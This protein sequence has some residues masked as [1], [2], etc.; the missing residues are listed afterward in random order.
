MKS[1][2]AANLS[3]GTMT[4]D[5][6]SFSSEDQLFDA[7]TESAFEFIHKAIAEFEQS[8]K[9]STVNFAIAIELILKAKLLREHWSLLLEKPD[10]ADKDSFRKG[11]SHTISP[12]KTIE[13]LRRVASVDV[14][15]KFREIFKTI[16]THRNKMVHF[17]HAGV[18]ATADQTA[19][20]QIAEEQCAGWYALRFLLRQWPEFRKFDDEI[21]RIGRGMERHRAYLQHAFDAKAEDLNKHRKAGLPIRKCPV[22]S[23]DSVMVEESDGTIADTSCVVCWYGGSEITLGCPNEDCAN[24]VI[25][26][27]YDGAPSE[28]ATCGCAIS[29]ED[30]SNALDTGE[31]VTKDNYYDIVAISC[32]ECSGYH[33]VVEHNEEYICTQCFTRSSEMGVCGYC[34]E[35]QL[36]GVP[37]F[38]SI[39]GCNACPGSSDFHSDD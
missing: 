39:T 2:R 19:A 12:E 20:T 9:F 26:S 7:L 6:S 16:A 27:S 10:Q 4:K 22:C 35:G 14:P 1:K 32:P 23:F 5:N 33:T 18:T 36:G 29:A 37:E 15:L 25:F 8:P 30:I 34:G 13:R 24:V 3:V 28:C 38:S 11:E 21:W 17:A 31:P